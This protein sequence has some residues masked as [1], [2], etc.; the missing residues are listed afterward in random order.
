MKRLLVSILA[1]SLW[2][3]ATGC[4]TIFHG[5]HQTV[6]IS[7]AP[8]GSEVSVYRW[9]GEV[10]GGPQLSRGELII[11]R[12]KANQPYLVRASKDGYCPKYWLTTWS[13][14]GGTQSYL[15]SAFVPFLDIVGVPLLM[16]DTW[17]GGCCNVEPDS[18]EGVL[19]EEAA[20]GQ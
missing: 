19:A 20:C 12:P 14:T 13:W 2:F 5:T 18:F 3:N 10:V 8:P 4:G 15:W 16:F 17:T 6:P 7:V 11:Q 9:S 1:V